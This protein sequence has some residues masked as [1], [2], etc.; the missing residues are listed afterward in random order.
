MAIPRKGTRTITVEGEDFRWL[1]RR[2]A[3][4]SQTDYGSGKIHIAIENATVKGAKLHIETDRPHP[5]D[6]GTL[7][8]EPVT[9]ADIT[10]WISMAVQMGWDP[11]TAGPMLRITKEDLTGSHT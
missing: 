5:K 10:R 9:P 2:K 7:K 3:T 11:K 8:V 1:V 6:W 4:F